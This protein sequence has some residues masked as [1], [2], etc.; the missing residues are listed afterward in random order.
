[1][2]KPMHKK[3]KEKY[4]INTDFFFKQTFFFKSTD[5]KR[6]QQTGIPINTINKHTKMTSTYMGINKHPK[7]TSTYT[8]INK[9]KSDINIHEYQ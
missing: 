9:H 5:T 2:N 8:S 1:M 7:V 3:E 4:T 6:N